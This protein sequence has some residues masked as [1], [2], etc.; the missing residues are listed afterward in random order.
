M[1]WTVGGA[2]GQRQARRND[3]ETSRTAISQTVGTVVE[4]HQLTTRLKYRGEQGLVQRNESP[5]SVLV[6]TCFSAPPPAE[7]E[8]RPL[9]GSGS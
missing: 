6:L 2:R 8:T 1:C 4:S 7:A 9:F 3:E 5:F